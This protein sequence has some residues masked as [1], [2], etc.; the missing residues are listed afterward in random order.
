M[1]EIFKISDHTDSNNVHCRVVQGGCT[2]DG[3]YYYVA[4]NNNDKTEASI[5]AILKYEIATGELVKVFENVKTSHCNDL[6]YNP[7]TN[8]MTLF[9]QNWR[10]NGCA[11]IERVIPLHGSCYRVYR[12]VTD[13]G[14]MPTLSERALAEAELLAQP[15]VQSNSN[16]LRQAIRTAELFL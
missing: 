13:E 4:L 11:A 14:R 10:W 12:L 3:T 9:E 7:E 15:V 5:N 2:D 1:T 6:T 8:E 16:L